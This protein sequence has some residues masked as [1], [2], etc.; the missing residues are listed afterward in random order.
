MSARTFFLI[1]SCTHTRI[2]ACTYTY[3]HPHVDTHINRHTGTQTHRH[4]QMYDERTNAC[5]ICVPKNDVCHARNNY[6]SR[7][8]LACQSRTPHFAHAIVPPGY[9]FSVREF[10]KGEDVRLSSATIND[11]LFDAPLPLVYS[12]HIGMRGNEIV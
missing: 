9:E 10:K 3:I 1:Y 4:A 7:T 5:V 8:L 12:F 6:I 11:P 2:H